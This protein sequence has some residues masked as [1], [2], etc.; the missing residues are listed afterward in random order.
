MR[1]EVVLNAGP[2]ASVAVR[3]APAVDAEQI[4]GVKAGMA[5]AAIAHCKSLGRQQQI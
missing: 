3:T 5:V 4:H 2:D 1:S